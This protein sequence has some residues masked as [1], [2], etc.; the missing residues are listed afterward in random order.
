MTWI[1]PDVERAIDGVAQAGFISPARIGTSSQFSL[2]AKGQTYS[3]LNA[4]DGL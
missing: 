1:A 3:S 4:Q 2:G